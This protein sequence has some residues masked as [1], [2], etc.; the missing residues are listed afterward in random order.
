MKK[1]LFLGN[2]YHRKTGS[3]Q[4]LIK[5]LESHYSV[6]LCYVCLFEESPWRILF[7]FEDE[8]F[9]VI[10]CWQVMPPIAELKKYIV[11][12]N[13]VLFPMLDGC[14]SHKKPEKWYPYRN[15]QIVSFSST[16]QKNLIS[17]GFHPLYVQYFP[18]PKKINTLGEPDSLF[19]WNR[20]EQININTVFE[21]IKNSRIRNVHIHKALD[22]N[23]SFIYPNSN[24]EFLI[25]YSDWYEDKS[26]MMEEIESAAYYM[27]PREKEGIGMSFLEAM[28][29]GRCVV[30]PNSPTM[31]EYIM[32][33][34]NGYLYDLYNLK[35]MGFE[36]VEKIQL[37]TISFMKEGYQK[38]Q[39][40]IPLIIDWLECIPQVSH[41]K[42]LRALVFRF[43][44]NPIKVMRSIL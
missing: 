20:R 44:K 29:M 25:K 36:D 6:K 10:V 30:A 16:L 4:F 33:G 11:Y 41:L 21:I 42:L 26:D 37:N 7:D 31:N 5:I 12:Q 15:F 24:T 40:N 14:P 28:A 1:L 34:Y 8:Q 2:E 27:A 18:P 13:G 9:D 17:I 43:F 38:W 35:P 19:F 3:A 32:H 39:K 23:Q 22:P